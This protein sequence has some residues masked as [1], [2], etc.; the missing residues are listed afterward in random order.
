[1]PISGNLKRSRLF[2]EALSAPCQRLRINL[3]RLGTFRRDQHEY[4][5][6][7]QASAVEPQQ[8][9]GIVTER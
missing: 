4:R 2:S 1:L 8:T 3:P 9:P 5:R 6:Y 7:A